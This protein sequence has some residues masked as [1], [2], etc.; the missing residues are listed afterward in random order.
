VQLLTTILGQALDF[1]VRQIWR[2]RAQAGSE[3]PNQR[4]WIAVGS[5]QEVSPGAVL[6]R[7]R[8]HVECR[9]SIAVIELRNPNNVMS[10]C[11]N[12]ADD[13]SATLLQ[14]KLDTMAE[15]TLPLEDIASH[16]LVDDDDW[17]ATAVVNS[18]KR[19]P[20]DDPYSE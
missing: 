1:D 8:W 9:V 12:D 3:D 18:A 5:D 4:P 15:R 20:L 14:S 19:S 11:A 16:F 2:N 13:L 6:L 7:G 10:N 17:R